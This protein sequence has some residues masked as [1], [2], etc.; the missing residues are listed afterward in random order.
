MTSWLIGRGRDLATTRAAV[1]A[2][3]AVAV[4]G[5]AGMGKTALVRTALEGR[6]HLI[7]TARHGLVRRPYLALE[8]V[9][10]EPL[11]GEPDA[12]AEAVL[13]AVRADDATR[14]LVVEDL[15]WAHDLTLAALGLLVGRLPLVVTARDDSEPSPALDALIDQCTEVR[16][17]P[18][19]S[20][21]A[22]ALA[23]RAH[24]RLAPAAR[25]ELL[26][27]AG[28]NPLLITRLVDADRNVS[29]SLRDAIAARVAG[30]DEPNRRRLGLLALLGRAAQPREL[31][32][33]V[34][35]RLPELMIRQP[36]GTVTFGH[37][38]VGEA[39]A[40]TLSPDARIALH[41]ELATRLDDVESAAHRLAA[42]DEAGALA[43]AARALD[44]PENSPTVRAELARVAADA[45]RALERDGDSVG[46]RVTA[47]EAFVDAGQWRDALDQGTRIDGLDG[48]HEAAE[49]AA[50]V[51]LQRGR[52]Q[53]FLGEPASARASFDRA[54][55]H[56]ARLDGAVGLR[57][58]IMVEQAFLEVRDNTPG[59]LGV[60]EAAVRAAE[61][62]GVEVLRA[63]SILGT[64]QLFNGLPGWEPILVA[65][66]DGARQ[67]GR[68]ELEASIAYHLVIGL[69]FNARLIEAIETADRAR[70]RA[71]ESGLGNWSTNLEQV[72][73]IQR[74]VLSRDPASVVADAE[75][76][77]ARHPLFRNRPNTHTARVYSLLDLGRFDEAARA[78]DEMRAE[79]DPDGGDPTSSVAGG[80]VFV[81]VCEA[82]LAW[83][84]D[85]VA[86]AHAALVRGRRCGDAFYGV[87]VLAEACA[88]H[89]IVANGERFDPSAPVVLLPTWRP[90]LHEIEG[91]R[92]LGLGD[93]RA[94]IDEL[95]VAADRFSA[96]SV[97]RWAIRSFLTAV[98]VEAELGD[99]GAP[100]RR[101]SHIERARAA[102]LVG[103][104]RRHQIAFHPAL[105]ATE[106]AILREV[107]D[108]RITREI[109]E[110]FAIGART[111]D[112]HVESACRKLGAGTR[113]EAAA[114]V[115]S[116]RSAPEPGAEARAAPLTDEHLDLLRALGT[117]ATVGTAARRVGMSE[118]TASRRLAE[119]RRLLGVATNAEAVVAVSRRDG[120]GART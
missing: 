100:A 46:H 68:P 119:A 56:A 107:A 22:A 69:G 64:A 42:G 29:A 7:G 48:D 105:T 83:H 109:A 104:L 35:V 110:R 6:P 38:A 17:G 57:T 47:M 75:A 106:E 11:A 31:D 114:M 77:L 2:S 30:A 5:A 73:F 82:E 49:L 97:E 111:V 115:M 92:L 62:A 50:R 55:S 89:T 41:H 36:D 79:F 71:E 66:H 26:R 103:A 39:V 60:A 94:A 13:D 76:H 58:R 3:T 15:Q 20:R 51:E 33:D 113:V 80:E 63:L 8:H 116:D 117:G 85:D 9:V 21:S 102:G 88:G 118:R 108:G 98:D 72:S 52:A 67:E 32:V 65:A 120:L 61:D 70:A 23:R 86:L 1:D 90:A 27:Q 28:G 45:A 43:A 96:M 4:I 59:A 74:A 24:P 40:A 87:R 34:D 44:G 112:Q 16:L 25:D 95:H 37:A 81:A 54:A 99:R 12:V 19:P 84:T 93:P 14:C 10:G 101:R 53:W 18:L 78:V 91:L